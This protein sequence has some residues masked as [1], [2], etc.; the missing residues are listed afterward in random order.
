MLLAWLGGEGLPMG[1]DTADLAAYGAKRS[2]SPDVLSCVLRMPF[3][4]YRAA[5]VKRP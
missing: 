2:I 1:W 4:D 3:N 5:L